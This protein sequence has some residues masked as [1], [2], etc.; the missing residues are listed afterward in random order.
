M[1]VIVW[2]FDRALVAWLL[3]TNFFL[4]INYFAIIEILIIESW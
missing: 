4:K 3:L 1:F 2:P